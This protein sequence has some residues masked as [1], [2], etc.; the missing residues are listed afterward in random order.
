MKK[1]KE[2]EKKMVSD[3][4]AIKQDAIKEA[5][6]EKYSFEDFCRDDREASKRLEQSEEEHLDIQLANLKNIQM[7]YQEEQRLK[8]LNGISKNKKN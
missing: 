3:W 1:I 5:K 2:I 8:N 4:D 6:K 7:K